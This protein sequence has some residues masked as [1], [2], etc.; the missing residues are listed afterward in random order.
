MVILHHLIDFLKTKYFLHL[1]SPSIIV[2]TIKGVMNA[3]SKEK[4]KKAKEENQ[5]VDQGELVTQ[6]GRGPAKK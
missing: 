5:Q 3:D 4:E 6:L 1:V 2:L